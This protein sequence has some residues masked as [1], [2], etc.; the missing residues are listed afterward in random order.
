MT[1]YTSK[2]AQMYPQQLLNRSKFYSRCKKCDIDRTVGGGYHPPL[3]SLKVN[4]QTSTYYN[5]QLFTYCKD[6]DNLH[7]YIDISLASFIAERNATKRTTAASHNNRVR[8]E[9]IKLN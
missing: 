6:L 3:G 5:E 1:I 2:C 7:I 8:L 4:I 9:N